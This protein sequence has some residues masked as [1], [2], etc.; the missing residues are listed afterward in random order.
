[1]QAVVSAGEYYIVND[2]WG[3]LLTG[4]SGNVPRLMD[5]DGNDDE[6]FIFVAEESGTNGYVRLKQK[7]TGLYLAASAS[8]NW[9]VQLL[10]ESA[11]TDNYLWSLEQL[12]DTKIVNKKN[13]GA[14]L[15]SDFYS[16]S[17]SNWTY[18][19]DAAEVPVYYNKGVGAMTW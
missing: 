11:N 15:G 13:T 18:Y 17:G 7:S 5:Y 8:N 19:W 6:R 14:R 1:M 9:S 12:F 4:N 10:S 3:K 2:L 16:G